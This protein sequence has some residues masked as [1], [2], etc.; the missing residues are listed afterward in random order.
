MKLTI[1]D[2]D[3]F[4]HAVMKD[5]PQVDYEGQAK[6]MVRAECINKLP[7]KIK[8][9]W[10][11][12]DLRGFIRCDSYVR[13]DG[14]IGSVAVPPVE[15]TMSSSTAKKV[16][17]LA[18]KHKTQRKSRDE[19]RAKVKAMIDGCSTL[20]QA[21]DRLPEFS[22]YLPTERGSTGVVGLPIVAN[23]VSDLTKA[24]WPKDGSKS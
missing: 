3:A 7:P 6:D 8:A 2:R 24:G 18:E 19:L 9:L 21:K 20:K 15:Y 23:I 12:K 13:V 4:V 1:S 14:F 10:S 16:K 22:K 5:V 17:A 11:D